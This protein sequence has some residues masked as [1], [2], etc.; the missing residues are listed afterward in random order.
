MRPR[1][2][3]KRAL[4]SRA[5]MAVPQGLNQRWSLDFLSDAFTDGRRFRIFAVVDDFTRECLALVADTSLSGVRVARELDGL[6]AQRGKPLMIVSDNGTEFTSMAM[7]RWSQDHR[8]E[9][10]YIAPGK[11][12]Q[13]GFVESFNG[14]LRDEC[15]NETLFC[16]VSHARAVLADWKDDYN[17]VRPHTALDGIAPAQAAPH[18]HHRPFRASQGDGTQPLTGINQGN[19]SPWNFHPAISRALGSGSRNGR[20]GR[21]QGQPWSE[22]PSPHEDRPRNLVRRVRPISRKLR[23]ATCPLAASI[24]CD[25]IL[26]SAG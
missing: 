16:S 2:G 24:G 11:P 12:M 9:W 22:E 18:C 14:K 19:R 20:V 17:H 3:R 25:F 10:H 26:F 7:L 23:F 13:N 21:S 6:V 1:R 5:P 8:V 4:G 15:L